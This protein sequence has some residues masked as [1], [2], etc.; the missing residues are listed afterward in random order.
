MILCRWS[1]AVNL[2]YSSA[3]RVL[4]DRRTKDLSPELS[5]GSQRKAA[6][7]QTSNTIWLGTQC[8]VSWLA[9]F[10]SLMNSST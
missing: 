8:H 1:L 10:Q 4:E 6:V 5:L 7:E 9:E 2:E 3:R